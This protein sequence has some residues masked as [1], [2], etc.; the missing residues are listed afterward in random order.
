MPSSLDGAGDFLGAVLRIPIIRHQRITV[1]NVSRQL[2]IIIREL[3]NLSVVHAQHFGLFRC[4]QFETGDQVHD[5][6]DEAGAAEGV[7]EA[8]E[9]V[10]ELV[11]ELDPV[12]VEPAAVDDGEAVEVGYVVAVG[13]MSV[14]ARRENGRKGGKEGRREGGDVRSE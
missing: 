3:S 1:N 12:S 4:P 6:E 13:V 5:E 7:G 11:G 10:G 9:G 2:N 8:R 14:Y